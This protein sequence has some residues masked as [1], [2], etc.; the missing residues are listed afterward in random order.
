MGRFVTAYGDIR[1][2]MTQ[3]NPLLFALL[4]ASKALLAC[5]WDV[6]PPDPGPSKL[7]KARSNEPRLLSPVGSIPVRQYS[8]SAQIDGTPGIVGIYDRA[9]GRLDVQYGPSAGNWAAIGIH[10]RNLKFPRRFVFGVDGDSMLF[11]QVEFMNNEISE[12]LI[13]RPADY[14]LEG[15]DSLQV[16]ELVFS[17]NTDIVKASADGKLPSGSFGLF[18]PLQ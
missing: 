4:L 2:F 13:D 11:A 9:T 5:A 3:C 1:A 16:D 15:L 17:V 8:E 10:Y 6:R 18:L 7:D 12:E 14:V